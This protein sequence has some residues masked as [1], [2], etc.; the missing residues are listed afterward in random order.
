MNLPDSMGCGDGSSRNRV[1]REFVL[2]RPSDG[3]VLHP[4][5]DQEAMLLTSEAYQ[6]LIVSGAAGGR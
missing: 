5:G 1:A 3:G 6:E 4:K 2:L